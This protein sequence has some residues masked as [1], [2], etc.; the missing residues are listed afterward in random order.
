[1][2]IAYITTA[3]LPWGG[4]EELWS[5]SANRALDEHHEVLVSFF[6]RG[7]LPGQL[8]KLRQRGATFFF[9]RPVEGRVGA[10]IIRML[11]WRLLRQPEY[12]PAPRMS[13]FRHLFQLS[14]DVVCL[15]QGGSY[16]VANLSDLIE[17]LDVFSTPYVVIC[18]G[19]A[20]CYS[21]SE[22]RREQIISYFKKAYRVC[23]VAR[24]NMKLAERQLATRIENG[25]IIKNPYNLSSTDIVP[26]PNGE[27]INLAS[28]ARFEVLNKGQDILFETLSSEDWL[29]RNWQ[30]RLYGKGEDR[31]Y[32][33][34]LARH[35]GISDRVK[36]MG[37][38]NDIRALWQDNHVLVMPSR[39]EGTPLALVEA[40]LCG[41]PSVV[42]DVGGMCEWVEDSVNGYVAEAPSVRSFG[43]A[44]EK[45]WNTKSNWREMGI[46][47]HETARAKIDPS[48]EL[49]L[50][51]LLKAAAMAR[52]DP[53]P[54]K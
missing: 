14:P 28:V 3:A 6:M 31:G 17:L 49:K 44:L 29:S 20:E 50:I 54:G 36:F 30:L 10:R 13:P 9:N 23:F 47:A 5:S 4:S 52:K 19:G 22:A 18:Q 40:M 33:E 43:A 1:M 37:H 11:Q 48:P 35:F 53:N 42:S 16:D 8:L 41:R 15:N 51:D 21:P 2:K 39:I 24:E 12:T 7:D 34:K 38:V 46:R 26:Y 45:A 32:L 27:R 25:I